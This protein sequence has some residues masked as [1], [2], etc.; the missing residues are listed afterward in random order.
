MIFQHQRTA[1]I[2]RIFFL[3]RSI[4]DRRPNNDHS[5]TGNLL[6]QP[7][8]QTPF[9]CQTWPLK[10]RQL[11]HTKANKQHL[12]HK[13]PSSAPPHN[14]AMLP[15]SAPT[16]LCLAFLFALLPLTTAQNAAAG[17]GAGFAAAPV[18]YPTVV[19]VPSLLVE[20]GTTTVVQ[21]PFTQTFVT[22]LATWAFP[23]PKVGSVGL[24]SIQG[25]IG[26]VRNP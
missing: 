14:S 20:G 12:H 13:D 6:I 26:T 1:L 24:G 25:R 17:G 22:P 15:S 3:T 11:V 18:Q 5:L 7:P 21:Q 16:S 8:P 23:T 2:Q 9:F 19:N 10:L 4:N